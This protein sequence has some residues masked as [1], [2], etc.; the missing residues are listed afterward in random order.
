MEPA[1]STRVPTTSKVFNVYKAWCED[2]NNRYYKMAKEFR[3][4]LAEYLGVDV[5]K[6]IK[7]TKHGSI[8]DGYTLNSEARNAYPGVFAYDDE[9]D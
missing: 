1:K 4:G 9:E 2:N 8:F 3:E 7:H 5:K 6:L